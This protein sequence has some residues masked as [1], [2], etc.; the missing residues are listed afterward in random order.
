M[1]LQVAATATVPDAIKADLI[2][3]QAWAGNYQD[4]VED[5]NGDLVANPETK[6]QF[7]QRRANEFFVA[8]LKDDYLAYKENVAR[9]TARDTAK[10]EAE[11]I[12]VA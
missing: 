8:K 10:T 6:A 7:A 12:S 4:Q 5:E 11:T 2:K 9:E 1:A 3:S